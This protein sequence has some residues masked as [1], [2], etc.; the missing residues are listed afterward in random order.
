M[1]EEGEWVKSS[2]IYFAVSLFA[3]LFRLAYRA[4]REMTNFP[5]I[6]L[7]FTLGISSFCNWAKQE[8][9]LWSPTTPSTSEVEPLARV[10]RVGFPPGKTK[11]LCPF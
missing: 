3:S 10:F 4:A 1:Q 5:F 11:S 8:L 9:I 2:I 7:L 6:L